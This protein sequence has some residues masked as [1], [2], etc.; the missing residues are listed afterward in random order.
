MSQFVYDEQKTPWKVLCIVFKLV[1]SYSKTLSLTKPC[2]FI[3]EVLLFEGD[4]DCQI[5]FSYSADDEWT[6]QTHYQATLP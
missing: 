1:V 4:F 5:F 2:L 6:Q 3:L